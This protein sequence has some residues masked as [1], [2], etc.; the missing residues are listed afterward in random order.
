M[1]LIALRETL[2]GEHRVSV[3]PE[4]AKGLIQLGHTV[5]VEAGAGV[6][7]SFPDEEYTE[8]GVQVESDRSL[9]I[10][11]ADAWL[12]VQPPTLDEVDQLRPRS[13]LVG[14]LQP[15]EQLP[16]VSH[17][18]NRDVTSVA[19]ELLPRTTIAQSMDALSSQ[20]SIA[21]YRAVILASA[22]QTKILPMMTTPAGTIPPARVLVIGAGVAG[23]Q[24]I[25]TAHRLG[26]RVEA[27][28]TRP[29]V[30]EQVE[31]LGARFME[32]ELDVSDGEATGGYAKAQGEEFLQ[33]QRALFAERLKDFDIVV[34]T[35]LIPGMAAPKL[36]SEAAVD[37][38]HTGAVI[39]DLAAPNGGNCE[40]TRPD[41]E[42]NHGGVRI[43][44]PTNLAAESARGASRMYSR[45][46]LAL[47]RHLNGEEGELHYDLGDE[48]VAGAL[49]T[50]RGEVMNPRI[51]D[52]A[53]EAGL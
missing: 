18:A 15:Y 22:Y 35:A 45:N 8:Q 14:F 20:A 7:A 10:K 1:R 13:L 25:A 43:F 9:L 34:T 42:V 52:R 16:L 12:A 17:L 23:L 33:Q 49:L 29:V 6:E 27:Y 36:I 5:A 30:K 47:I 3:T 51:R 41:E 48:L 37:A 44:G 11:S 24:A 38:M 31:S 39:M 26:A 2:L 50:H 21:G 28:D 4:S 40:L 19:M 53:E 32:L 46:L